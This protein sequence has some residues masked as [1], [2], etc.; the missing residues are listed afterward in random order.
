MYIKKEN[1]VLREAEGANIWNYV[2]GDMEASFSVAYA[3][4]YGTHPESISHRSDRCYMF[5][6][7]DAVMNVGEETYHVKGGE[8]VYI[9]K[10]IKHSLEG[11]ITYYLVNNPPFRRE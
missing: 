10:G 3:E 6:E 9:P 4:V 5:I 2:T 1:A 11:K 7:G 8:V